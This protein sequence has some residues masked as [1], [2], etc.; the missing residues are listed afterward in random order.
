MG[1]SDQN[2]Y[3]FKER[4]T[5][6]RNKTKKLFL[7]FFTSAASITVPT[8]TVNACFGT[9]LM[10]LPKNLAFASKVSCANVFTLVLET[11]D[12][13]GSLKAM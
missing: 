5:Q 7:K 11:K 8:P 12:E 9:L 13:P 6:N 3:L 10:S 4:N 1:A 2:H